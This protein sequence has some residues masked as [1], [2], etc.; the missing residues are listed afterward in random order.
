[1]HVRTHTLYT[2]KPKDANLNMVT[3]GIYRSPSGSCVQRGS[4]P[5]GVG[6]FDHNQVMASLCCKWQLSD[7]VVAASLLLSYVEQVWHARCSGTNGGPW[8]G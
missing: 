3:L 5:G 6:L 2:R 7:I 4:Q 8:P 1:M